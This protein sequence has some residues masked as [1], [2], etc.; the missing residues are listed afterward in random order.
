MGCCGLT[1]EFC[2]KDKK[3]F[4]NC[5][6]GNLHGDTRGDLENIA[7]WMDSDGLLAYDPHKL[8]N[9]YSRVHYAFVNINSDFSIDDNRFSQSEFLNI[10]PKKI[11][12]FGGRLE[13][14]VTKFRF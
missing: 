4:S 10:K 8:D 14:I 12:S 2:D 3:C 13:H 7:Y 5:G 6:Y 1:S 11:A 9:E